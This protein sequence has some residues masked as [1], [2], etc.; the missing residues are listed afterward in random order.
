MAED[1]DLASYY[2]KIRERGWGCWV[3]GVKQ[4]FVPILHPDWQKKTQKISDD[5]QVTVSWDPMRY[6]DTL[7]DQ[8]T[9]IE[10]FR[11]AK[12]KVMLFP[13]LVA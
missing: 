1:E 9:A 8:V 6:T 5:R 2:D 13:V 7:G 11:N 3:H 4:A 10:V 12:Y